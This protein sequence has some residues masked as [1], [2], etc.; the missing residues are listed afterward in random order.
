MVLAELPDP[1]TIGH[2]FIENPELAE[3][4]KLGKTTSRLKAKVKSHDDI[5]PLDRFQDIRR[6]MVIIGKG[7]EHRFPGD[8]VPVLAVDVDALV[9][10]GLT[11]GEVL[12][13]FPWQI[14]KVFC[15]GGKTTGLLENLPVL[16]FDLLETVIEFRP[17]IGWVGVHNHPVPGGTA[18]PLRRVAAYPR[19]HGINQGEGYLPHF[20]E[21]SPGE[22]E[23]KKI[24]HLIWPIK[25]TE[26]D[27]KVDP[28]ELSYNIDMIR[29]PPF[30]EDFGRKPVMERLDGRVT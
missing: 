18:V 27:F 9:H 3:G 24:R 6:H 16:R 17:I 26:Q 5:N 28:G 14:F 15:M 10:F 1:H 23:G 12:V 21:P 22:F 7:R 30:P 11:L 8:D 25:G 2:E 13:I 29:H 19:V 20:I 4:G